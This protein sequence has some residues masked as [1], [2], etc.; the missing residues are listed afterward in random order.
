[1]GRSGEVQ[2]VF[3]GFLCLGCWYVAWSVQVTWWG[4][5][6]MLVVRVMPVM[7]WVIAPLVVLLVR[8]V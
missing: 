2:W 3:G 1:M 7:Q 4:V 5:L 8:V 6:V